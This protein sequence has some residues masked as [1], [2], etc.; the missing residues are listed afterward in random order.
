VIKTNTVPVAIL[1]AVLFIQ[2]IAMKALRRMMDAVWQFAFL[3][4]GK[5]IAIRKRR[6]DRC[7]QYKS[8][9]IVSKCS[10]FHSYEA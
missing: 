2:Q 8:G 3:R 5:R 1:E 4:F 10:R 6:F 9:R 7:K